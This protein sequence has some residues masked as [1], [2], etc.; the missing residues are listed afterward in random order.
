MSIP[1]MTIKASGA[2]DKGLVR[3]SNQDAYWI[4]QEKGI[5]IVADGM[6][7]HAGGEI[8]SRL[9]VNEIVAHMTKNESPTCLYDITSQR[10]SSLLKSLSVSVNHASA[11]IY[12]HSLEEPSLRGMGT[13]TTLVKIIGKGAFCAHVGDSRLYLLRSGFL[14]QLSLDHSLVQEQLRAGLITEEEASF[15]HLRN[16]ITRSVGY[17]EEEE[18]DTFDF[19][20][21][22]EDL[23]LLCSDGLHGK[24]SDREIS[25][26]LQKMSLDAVNYLINLAKT[27]GG[28]DN[29]T[30]VIIKVQD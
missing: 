20:L 3:E 17:Q 1:C 30:V 6:G 29:I 9:C 12:E 11:K 22:S 19:D 4:D 24:V 15:H 2:T 8:A 26:H 13:T 16:V 28:E 23:L 27:R 25:D 7:G 18:V 5:F 14:Y 21:Q 10:K